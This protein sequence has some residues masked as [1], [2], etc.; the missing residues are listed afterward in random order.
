[1]TIFYFKLEDYNWSQH[2]TN[3]NNVGFLKL[4]WSS[5]CCKGN[6]AMCWDG[7]FIYEVQSDNNIVTLQCFSCAIFF[8]ELVCDETI[9][10]SNLTTTCMLY[11]HK[12]EILVSACR[13]GIICCPCQANRGESEASA[14][15]ECKGWVQRASYVRGKERWKIPQSFIVLMLCVLALVSCWP[16]QSAC[17]A[18]Y[19]SVCRKLLMQSNLMKNHSS[20]K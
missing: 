19:I 9:V 12:Y 4:H 17:S 16:C 11:L 18:G 7:Q 1:M 8:L 2:F 13:A 20:Q 3:T 14:K 5:V 15:G 6:S 10:I